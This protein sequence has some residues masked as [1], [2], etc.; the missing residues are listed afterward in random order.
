MLNITDII[1]KTNIKRL[2]FWFAD[3]PKQ[4]FIIIFMC[5]TIGYK[6]NSNLPKKWIGEIKAVFNTLKHDGS[7]EFISNQELISISVTN[8][9]IPRI[10]ENID[11]DLDKK[12]ETQLH[13]YFKNIVQDKINGAKEIKIIFDKNSNKIVEN[14]INKGF[15]S[16]IIVDDINLNDELIKTQILCD[17]VATKNSQTKSCDWCDIKNKSGLRY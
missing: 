8:Y 15:H 9:A 11:K 17:L 1:N 13:L 12:C 5:I 2:G 7:L 6:K 3:N 16:Q 14:T 4:S 10:H